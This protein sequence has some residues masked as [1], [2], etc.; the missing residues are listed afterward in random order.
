MLLFNRY[1][2]QPSTDLIGKG[3]LTRVYKALDKQIYLPVALKIY[4]G[5]D[6]LEKV[7]LVNVKKFIAMDHP[8]ICR[9]LHIEDVEK[10]GP[11]GEKE[12]TQVCVMELVPDG[13]FGSYYRERNDTELLRR[14]VTDILRGLAYLHS[15]GIVHRRLKPSNLLVGETTQGPVVKITDFGLG[16]GKAALRDARLSSIVVEVTHM[17]PEQ[18]NPRKYGVNGKVSY[19]LDFWAV[20]LAI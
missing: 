4:R 5:G 15:K 12:R 20:G 3:E 19:H 17:A 6:P 7:G 11:L 1:Q 9:Y 2:Y 10:D 14:M 13:D 18:F 16:A 8:N